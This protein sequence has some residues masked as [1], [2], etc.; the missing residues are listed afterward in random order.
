MIAQIQMTT[1]QKRGGLRL[2]Q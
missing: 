2:W 1:S